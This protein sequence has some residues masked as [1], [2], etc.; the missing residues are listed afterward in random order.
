MN[1][2]FVIVCIYVSGEKLGCLTSHR[3]V[4]SEV[5][6]VSVLDDKLAVGT[7]QYGLFLFKIIREN[8]D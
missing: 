6:D 4:N 7:R 3:L 2:S 1:E 5:M 8:L